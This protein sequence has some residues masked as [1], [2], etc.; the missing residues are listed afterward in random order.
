MKPVVTI[1]WQNWF[2]GVGWKNGS[3]IASIGPVTFLW[4]KK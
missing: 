4:V 2:I 1:S 3:V